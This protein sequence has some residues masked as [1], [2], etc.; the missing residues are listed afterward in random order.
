MPYSTPPPDLNGDIKLIIIIPDGACDIRYPELNHLSPLEYARTPGIDRI[1]QRG[2]VGMVQTMYK[3]L[4]LGSLVGILG[5]LGYNPV[6]HFPVG[7]AL[8]EA[9]T[10]GI[11]LNPADVAFRCNIVRI[12]DQQQLADFTAGQIGNEAAQAYLRDISLPAPFELYHDVSYRNVL[13]WRG[14][15]LPLQKLSLAE[16]HEHMGCSIEAIL[17]RF[18]HQPYEPLT[19]LIF[20]S[21][22]SDLTLWP[23][24]ASRM[25]TF[26][27]SPFKVGVVTG[28]SFL[29]GMT[30][31]LGGQAVMP[32]GAT[33]Y[34]DTD[35]QAKLSALIRQLPDIDVGVIHCNAPDEEAHV[36]NLAGKIQ[37]IEAI[38]A[39]VVTPLLEY[40]EDS[41]SPYRI[42]ICPD[43]Y[44]CCTTGKHQPTP[45]P[46]AV[47]GYALKPNHRFTAYSETA[48]SQVHQQV[49]QSHRL[50]PTFGSGR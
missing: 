10:L 4:P 25:R 38:D 6:E 1:V 44:T 42:M 28:L 3:G 32:P 16:P 31:M 34:L 35:L 12:N 33:G 48:I 47:A 50:I 20:S 11:Q 24:G 18:R 19:E 29:Y 37:A 22:R 8:F 7:R 5:I 26:H 21:R 30:R 15:S 36:K 27:P 46:Y 43:H 40:I 13:V 23:W 49:I 17:P 45:V 9:H 39:E 14:C 2:R 41:A